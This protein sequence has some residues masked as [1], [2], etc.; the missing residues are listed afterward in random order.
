MYLQ[1]RTTEHRTYYLLTYLRTKGTKTKVLYV[2]LKTGRRKNGG[3]SEPEQ[4][5]L[6]FISCLLLASI[7]AASIITIFCPFPT[8]FEREFLLQSTI[9]SCKGVLF[10]HI[11]CLVIVLTSLISNNELINYE[12]D[13][14][15]TQ[16]KVG[17]TFPGTCG[18]QTSS[19]KLQCTTCQQ[20]ESTSREMG[21]DTTNNE[22]DNE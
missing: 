11:F 7:A 22:G 19:R 14:D 13:R 3:F 9:H 4:T 15:F 2:V 21:H 16:N 10:C 5:I 20:R 18:V 1:Y 12:Q 6:I 8:I 17:D